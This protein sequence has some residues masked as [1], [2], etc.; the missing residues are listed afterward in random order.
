MSASQSS[1]SL[2]FTQS[3]FT[4]TTSSLAESQITTAVE[5]ATTLP[6]ATTTETMSSAFYVVLDTTEPSSIV[7]A[8]NFT[9]PTVT[10]T[11]EHTTTT[12][13]ETTLT[14]S[15]AVV[16]T[17]QRTIATA[18]SIAICSLWMRKSNTAADRGVFYAL[19]SESD[20]VTLCLTS[21]SCVGFD[22]TPFGCTLHHDVG[23]LTDS[24]Y[25]PEVTQFVLKR[26]CL[27]VF[28][29]MCNHLMGDTPLLS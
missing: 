6:S 27:P 17:T 22:I 19:K 13:A 12:M 11:V 10:S 1:D 4:S 5:Q 16:G 23:E 7:S 2:S 21:L 9:E 29:T 3:T 14:S 25:S 26:H 15:D 28:S 24:Y 8:S 18:S 20:C